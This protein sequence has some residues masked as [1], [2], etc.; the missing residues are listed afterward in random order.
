MPSPL[1]HSSRAATEI[2]LYT[3]LTHLDLVQ[4][5]QRVPR[6]QREKKK[7]LEWV[8]PCVRLGLHEHA[9]HGMMLRFIRFFRQPP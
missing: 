2:T 7:V 6:V 3:I 9:G 8:F 1:N 5:A 4:G